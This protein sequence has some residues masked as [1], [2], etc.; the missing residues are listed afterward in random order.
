M[1][2]KLELIEGLIYLIGKQYLTFGLPKID[3]FGNEYR[4]IFNPILVNI[5]YYIMLFKHIICALV[6]DKR[7]SKLL[8]DFTYNWE[9]SFQWNSFVTSVMLLGLFIQFV[10]YFNFKS[11][12]TS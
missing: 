6:R 8:A 5:V 3:G 2:Y 4:F 7:I 9:F 1:E 10:M 11:K 12:M